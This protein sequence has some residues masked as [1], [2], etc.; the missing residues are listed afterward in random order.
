MRKADN[1][2]ELIRWIFEIHST[3]TMNGSVS[4]IFEK[5]EFMVDKALLLQPLYI[6]LPQAQTD[7][8]NRYLENQQQDTNDD[9]KSVFNDAKEFIRSVII[10]R[11]LPDFN[12]KRALGNKHFPRKISSRRIVER[13]QDLLDDGHIG[14]LQ[15]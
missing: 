9:I 14:F 13:Y 5:I 1:R 11:Q 12:Q 2:T 6:G 4:G 15:D 8:I 3:F 7:S 10:D